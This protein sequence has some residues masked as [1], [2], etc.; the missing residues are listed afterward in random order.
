M[1]VWVVNGW[2]PCLGKVQGKLHAVMNIYMEEWNWYSVRRAVRNRADM[3]LKSSKER[4]TIIYA[5]SKP[6]LTTEQ[7]NISAREER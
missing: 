7:Q 6:L 5:D 4:N 2:M 3:H 1:S